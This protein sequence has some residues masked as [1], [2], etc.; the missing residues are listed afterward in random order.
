V[1]SDNP[2][3][4]PLREASGRVDPTELLSRAADALERRPDRPL[5]C[6]AGGIG[7]P[8]LRMVESLARLHLL[9]RRSG[10][11]MR[12]IG[13]SPELLDLLA[14]CGFPPGLALEAQRQPEHRVEAGGVEE[15][16]DTR[17]PPV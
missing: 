4:L 5:L 9:V 2:P 15:E 14:F 12:L 1:R 10:G 6:D 11:S 7:R 13:A 17:D 3:R 16:R 8:N